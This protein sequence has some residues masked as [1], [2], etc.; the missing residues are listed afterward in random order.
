MSAEPADGAGPAPA[1]RRPRPAEAAAVVLLLGLHAGLA[2]DS[3]WSKAVTRDEN[4][5]LPAGLAAVATGEM[6]LNRQH[7]P[8]VKL[9]A[10]LAA[11][12]VAPTLPL[13][14]EAY[15]AGA[16]WDFGF[17]VLFAPGND[18]WG[19]LRRGRLPTVA[20][21][22]LGGLAVFAW[23]RALF[24]AAGGLLSLS[25]YA[26][27]PTVLAHARWVTMDVPVAAL[28]AWAL[29]AWWRAARS[30]LR[31]L[32]CALAGLALG[33]ALAAK[34]SALALLP[35]MAACELAA[36]RRAGFG[37][38]LAAWAIVLAAAALVLQAAYLSPAGPL[39][40]LRDARLI[41]ADHVPGYPF[42]LAG[43]FSP[44][45]YPHYFLVAMAVK[46]SLPSL[47]AMLW[48]LAWAGAITVRGLGGG[49]GRGFGGPAADAAFLWLP[50]LGWLAATCALAADIGVRYALPVYPLLFVL[51]G[52]LPRALARHSRFGAGVATAGLTLAQLTTAAAVHPDYLPYFN[53]LAGGPEHGPCWL[54]DSN[55][56][57]GQDLADLPAWLAAHGVG[58]VRLLHAGAASPGFYGV[59]GGPI[60]E[61]DWTGRPRPGWYVLSAHALV[62]GLDWADTRGVATDWLR[63]Y[64]PVDVLRGSMY[65][66]RFGDGEP[67]PGPW[68]PC[69]PPAPDRAAGERRPANA[70]PPPAPGGA[71]G[72]P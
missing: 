58:S 28:G 45:R 57:W 62:R 3:L 2:V 66:Y 30:G 46:S 60:E 5:H 23:S 4:S 21:S 13:D 17:E 59:A 67:A 36:A 44:E 20:L 50:A 54:D 65:L 15:R 33:L 41:N 56:D 37:R 18:H 69:T 29:F 55:L 47:L 71:E 49:L 22:V 53:R 48:G 39:E 25:L 19:M 68:P 11:A 35:A 26:F 72:A 24:G 14:G 31:P 1:R 70:A 38:R 10:G 64:R 34:F 6:R 9:L 52:S 42:Y 32:P 16:E 12:T 61:A 51:A 7:P 27:E 63:R 40:Y 8:L 43:S